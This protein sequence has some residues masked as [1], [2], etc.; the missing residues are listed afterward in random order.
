MADDKIEHLMLEQFRRLD[1]KVDRIL[2]AMRV[3]HDDAL[4]LRLHVRANTRDIDAQRDT[5]AN[6]TLRLDRVERRLELSDGPTAGLAEDRQPYDP[7]AP[8]KR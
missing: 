7:G 2:E 4:S 8:K 3:M 5:L 6:L 1:A